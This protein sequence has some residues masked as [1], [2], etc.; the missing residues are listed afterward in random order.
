MQKCTLKIVW[1]AFLTFIK[2]IQVN[3]I[4]FRDIGCLCDTIC[5]NDTTSYILWHIKITNVG[6]TLYRDMKCDDQLYFDEC[7]C[8]NSDTRNSIVDEVQDENYINMELLEALHHVLFFTLKVYWLPRYL[9]HCCAV[10]RKRHVRL[11]E[12]FE[13]YWVKNVLLWAMALHFLF[14]QVQE[15]FVKLR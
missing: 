4:F 6:R 2:A 1:L 8:I 10:N 15:N 9:I 7:Y 12:H 5:W 3:D 14:Q 13:Y 11:G